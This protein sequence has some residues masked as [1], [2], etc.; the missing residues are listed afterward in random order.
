MAPC[1]NQ[2]TM[3]VSASILNHTQGES[4]LFYKYQNPDLGFKM[5][6]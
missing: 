5:A 1:P 3:L 2:L 6:K 4:L